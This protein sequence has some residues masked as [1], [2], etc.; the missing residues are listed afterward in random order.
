MRIV[1]VTTEAVPYAKAGGLGDVVTPL[2]REL[3]RLGHEVR[4][5]MPFYSGMEKPNRGKRFF[6]HHGN[7]SFHLTLYTA[8]PEKDGLIFHFL[9]SPPL[10]EREGIYGSKRE[11]G[12]RD[13]LLRF[14]VFCHALYPSLEQLNWTPDIIHYHDWPASLVS[15]YG[16]ILKESNPLREEFSEEIYSN[17][18]YVLSIHNIGYQGVFGIEEHKAMDIPQS[19]LAS[20]GLMLNGTINL[21]QGGILNAHSITTVS[22]HY[23][24]EILTPEYGSGLE[25]VLLNRREDITGILN[26]MDYDQWDPSRDPYLPVPF[27]SEDLSGKEHVKATLQKT[28]GLPVEKETPL[29]GMVG[30]LVDQKGIVPFCAPD[31]GALYHICAEHPV[32]MVILGTGEAW[33]ERELLVL[34]K[35]LPNLK[36][37]LEFND[38]LAHLI[39]GGSDF[40]LMP[41]IYEPCGLN[42]MYSLRY[43]SI[44]IVTRTGG[45]VDTVEDYRNEGEKGKGT[46]FIF[47]RAAPEEI[48]EAVRRALTVW[49]QN[50]HHIVELRKRGMSKRFTWEE[51]AKRYTDVYKKGLSNKSLFR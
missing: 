33:C 9:E 45:L 32:Q 18:A 26:G 16:R 42:Q 44:P 15:M 43:G 5:Y 20:L 28:S 47:S 46:G 51:S 40:F 1:M 14:S 37:F 31:Y 22:P 24:E 17:P 35:K 39:E 49:Q 11:P 7:N 29:I 34:E 25:L 50:R 2:S 36:V 19:D 3:I 8:G 38:S 41:S 13:N 4:I 27:S 6:L 12:Y 21:L 10:F 30:R 48:V 23:A